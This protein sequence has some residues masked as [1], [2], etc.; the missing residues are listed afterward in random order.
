[1]QDGHWMGLTTQS[2]NDVELSKM[3]DVGCVGGLSESSVKG[4]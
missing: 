4:L 3:K 2:P 1:M